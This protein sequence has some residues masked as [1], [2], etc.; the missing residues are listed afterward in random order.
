MTQGV[1]CTSTGLMYLSHLIIEMKKKTHNWNW[2]FLLLQ[3]SRKP[4]LCL[5]S[6]VS[7]LQKQVTSK[8]RIYSFCILQV[9]V[10]TG[11]NSVF[12][13]NP[14]ATESNGTIYKAVHKSLCFMSVFLVG[15]CYICI[16]LFRIWVQHFQ[17]C[18]D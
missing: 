5:F 10:S 16:L 17:L 18:F 13:P 14:K 1:S 12:H 11:G 4:L 15:C 8:E 7:K 3:D 2:I 9:S 6:D